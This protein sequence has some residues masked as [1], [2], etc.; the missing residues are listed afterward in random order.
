MIPATSVS[1]S[2]LRRM[3]PMMIKR[4]NRYEIKYLLPVRGMFNII[5]ELGWFMRSDPHS[6]ARGGYKVSSLYYDSRDFECYRSK[7]DG[8]KFRRKIRIR[9]YDDSPSESVFLEIKQRMNKTV[10]KRRAALALQDAYAV[11]E[12]SEAV[13]SG[14]DADLLSEVRY[15][16]RSLQLRKVCVIRYHRRAFQGGKYEP[17]LRVTFDTNLRYRFHALDL[18]VPAPG[19]FFLPPDVCV[20]E[21]KANE[22]VP[23]WITSLLAR[24]QCDLSRVSKYCLGVKRGFEHIGQRR[25]ISKT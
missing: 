3:G 21:V 6:M 9:K 7:V 19:R 1:M 15:L 10:Q 17:G 11:C 18:D 2:R 4:F 24:H 8:I 22:K 13:S 23:I 25:M 5:D 16:S 14:D 12:G 20:M